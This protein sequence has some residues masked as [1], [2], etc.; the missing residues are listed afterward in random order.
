MDIQ[1]R[2]RKIFLFIVI[3]LLLLGILSKASVTIQNPIN[4]DSVLGSL[5]RE[6]M[7]SA[8]NYLLRGWYLPDNSCLFTEYPV[9]F[10]FETL[11]GTGTPAHRLSTFSIFILSVALFFMLL[12]RIFGVKVALV[13]I[14]FV[15][16]GNLF[17]ALHLTLCQYVHLSTFNISLLCLILFMHAFFHWEHPH[18]WSRKNE[19]ILI[20]ALFILI[21]LAVFSDKYMIVV[22]VI[23]LLL[24][25]AGTKISRTPVPMTRRL[26]FI[27]VLMILAVGAG[28]ILQKIAALGGLHLVTVDLGIASLQKCMYNVFL[29]FLSMANIFG[30]NFLQKTTGAGLAFM[31]ANLLFF[32]VVLWGAASYFSRVMDP[33]K[34][35]MV[36]FSVNSLFIMI[37]AFIASV[38]PYDLNSAR[39]LIPVFFSFALF[40]AL[41]VCDDTLALKPW[42]RI[43]IIVIFILQSLFNSSECLHF[44]GSQPEQELAGFL[45]QE[46][47]YYGYA[48]HWHSNIITYLSKN[49]VR[50][51][52]VTMKDGTIKPLLWFS[53]S[54][55]YSPSYYNGPTFLIMPRTG[56]VIAE[57]GIADLE[58]DFLEAL[59]GKPDKIKSHDNDDI[60]IWQKNI[61]ADFQRIDSCLALLIPEE[62][63]RDTG[64]IVEEGKSWILVAHKGSNGLMVKKMNMGKREAAY[65]VK[66]FVRAKGEERTVAAVVSA[67]ILDG[68]DKSIARSVKKEINAHADPLWEEIDVELST[69]GFAPGR[70][71]YEVNF[72]ATGSGEVQL[73]NLYVLR[74]AD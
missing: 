51:R 9:Y 20:M 59:C 3:P 4:S 13:G 31:G 36:L 11:L 21:M 25:V 60:Y 2:M 35:F 39:Y 30:F 54:D 63:D 58:P 46:R 42:V 28:V 64:H 72:A 48:S 47:L 18:G 43:A 17:S 68:K 41:C 29:Y 16:S 70:Y 52:S 55:W 33:I 73:R 37:I 74:L 5:I 24:S 45:E 53:K 32:V 71:G 38:M 26:R 23:P 8:H 7:I 6:D 50:V 34:S 61:A 27:V 19:K 15:I 10:L 1:S 22:F 69:K 44:R 65:L 12:R 67:V 62:L 49:K 14:L 57:A 56:S 66:A 40:A